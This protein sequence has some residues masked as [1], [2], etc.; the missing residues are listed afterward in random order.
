MTPLEQGE[1]LHP[2][3]QPQK[4]IA[5]GCGTQ[6][7]DVNRLLK[8]FEMLQQLTKSISRAASAASED[9][10]ACLLWAKAKKRA[11]SRASAAKTFEISARGIYII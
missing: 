4:R 3:R 8:S 5:A 10:A 1:S 9:P 2:Q 11:S 6:V 7:S